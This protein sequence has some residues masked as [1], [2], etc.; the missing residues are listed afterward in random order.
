MTIAQQNS[1]YNEGQTLSP[2]REKLNEVIFGSETPAGRN[3]DVILIVMI[4]LS[5]VVVMMDS[6]ED[7]S[8][9][10]AAWL[11]VL[12]W[13]FTGLFTLEYL[14]RLLCVRH[15]WLYIR[16]FY[17]IVDLLSILP[18]YIGLFLPGVE[19]AKFGSYDCYGYSGY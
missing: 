8:K 9:Q 15:P 14:L 2:W 18:S 12:E 11:S 16:S 19:Y 10:H 3:F 6:V 13:M 4:F 5:A 7:F 1:K 17:G